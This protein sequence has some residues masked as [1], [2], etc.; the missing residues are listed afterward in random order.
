M[1]DHQL[2]AQ[3]GGLPAPTAQFG[4]DLQAVRGLADLDLEVVLVPG[5]QAAGGAQQPVAGDLRTIAE[6]LATHAATSQEIDSLTAAQQ[7]YL[8]S[9]QEG[10]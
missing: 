3:S 6:T 8:A 9:W 2:E 4:Q 5:P 10:T 7:R 1:R